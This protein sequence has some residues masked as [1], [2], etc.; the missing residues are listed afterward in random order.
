MNARQAEK[1]LAEDLAQ[2]RSDPEGF[3]RYVYPW[4]EGELADSQGPWG[5]QREIMGLIRNHLRSTNWADPLQIA[6]ASGKG[7]GKSALVSWLSN[8]AMSTCGGCRVRLTANTE[9]QLKTITWPEV[10]KWFGMAPNA[11]WFDVEEES[12]RSKGSGKDDKLRKIWR[13]DRIT[14]NEK[15]PEAFGGLHNA[16]RRI[17]VVFDE[18]SGIPDVIWDQ[19]QST[20]TDRNTELI[21]LV[22]GNPMRNTGRFKECF[23]KLRH[24]W[25]TF[26]IDSRKVEGTN[27]KKLE[28]D[29][30]EYGGIDSDGAKIYVLGQFPSKSSAQF[31]SSDIVD[32]AMRYK[33]E[34]YQHMPK[35]ISCDV[36]RFGKNQT[37]IGFR[38]GR[39]SA[40]LAKHRGLDSV[41]VAER[42]IEFIHQEKPDAVVV[43]GDGNGAGVVDQL[44]ARKYKCFSFHGAERATKS[45][46][47]F[48]RRAEIW[49][50]MRDWIKE[51]AELPDDKE[52]VADL[53]GPE[54]LLSR[55]G[56]IQLEKKEDMERRGL[57][58]PDIGDMLAMSFAVDI[59]V[60]KKVDLEAKLFAPAQSWMSA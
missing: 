29:I 21:W 53:T 2:Y 47:Y 38:Q 46:K 56:Q 32:L 24:R 31:I 43:D 8:W 51:G 10:A 59:A 49:G 27:K 55:K 23:G 25:H 54:Y 45:E 60:S 33:A 5:W 57:S 13:C 30:E 12:I 39:K 36:A 35:V 58:S 4:G 6:V 16:G 26:Q 19:T 40:I 52:I 22:F 44:N 9:P 37:V 14:W 17:L 3:T 18:A 1:A 20:L 11:H 15:K 50:L 42:I 28:D 7:V 34:S 41:Q 48:N